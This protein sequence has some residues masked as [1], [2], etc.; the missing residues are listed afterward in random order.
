MFETVFNALKELA[1]EVTRK[2]A[3][4]IA[5]KEEMEY[6]CILFAEGWQWAD[7]PLDESEIEQGVRVSEHET[8][9][10]DLV[11]PFFP[12]A[13]WE[14]NAFVIALYFDK[15]DYIKI[16]QFYRALQEFSEKYGHIKAMCERDQYTYDMGSSI[17][18]SLKKNA[19]TIM[20]M[21]EE[22][23]NKLMS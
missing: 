13:M 3:F 20:K 16:A 7:R 1:V 14:N 6:C 11:V 12:K 22:G 17:W 8:R 18:S 21:K 19:E 10:I 15:E 23:I 4:L 5:L 9:A 2:R